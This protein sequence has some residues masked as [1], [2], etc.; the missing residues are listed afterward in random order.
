[1][2]AAV[3]SVR[4]HLC[5]GLHTHRACF[6]RWENYIQ[7]FIPPFFGIVLTS[8]PSSWKPAWNVYTGLNLFSWQT[9]RIPFAIPPLGQ[10]YQSPL[11][12]FFLSCVANAQLNH[13]TE[14]VA[15]TLDSRHG[16]SRALAR[17][18]ARA[19]SCQARLSHFPVKT[20]HL[21]NLPNPETQI[22]RYK[23]EL[24]QNLKLNMYRKIPRNPSFSIWWILGLSRPWLESRDFGRWRISA[25]IERAWE[26]LLFIYGHTIN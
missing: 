14:W 10:L 5:R 20:L 16:G 9:L 8:R 17:A 11:F 19:E 3:V 21:R 4:V 18:R 1:V 25:W 15:C 13:W 7:L 2:V 26:R 12:S 24:N 6:L 23:F 22:P